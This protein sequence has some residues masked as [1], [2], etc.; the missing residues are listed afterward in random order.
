MAVLP[1]VQGK[2]KGVFAAGVAVVVLLAGSAV[3][4]SRSVL[5]LWRLQEQSRGLERQAIGLHHRNEALRRHL[6][7]LRADDA[8]LERVIRQ[9]LGWV[10]E[11]EIV[12]RVPRDRPRGTAAEA[13]GAS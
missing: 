5:H 9:R 3:W 8:Y 4:G 11:G 2:Y 12:Y 13:S 1:P 7:R 10:G 6:R